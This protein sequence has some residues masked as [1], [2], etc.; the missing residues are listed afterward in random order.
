MVETSASTSSQ[1]MMIEVSY[2]SLIPF[3]E[4]ARI[5]HAAIIFI[6]IT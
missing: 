1:A 3:V 2:S 5:I 6:I 4:A